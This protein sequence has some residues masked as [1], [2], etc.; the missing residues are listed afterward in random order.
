MGHY[1]GGQPADRDPPVDLCMP[2]SRSRAALA[3]A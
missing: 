2:G 3:F 1:K